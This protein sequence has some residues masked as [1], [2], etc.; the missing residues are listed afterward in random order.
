MS[1]HA[2]QDQNILLD[3]LVLVFGFSLV[4]VSSSLTLIEPGEL[5]VLFASQL[6][7]EDIVLCIHGGVGSFSIPSTWTKSC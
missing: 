1:F 7:K 2:L 5:A 3:Q 6:T 4:L